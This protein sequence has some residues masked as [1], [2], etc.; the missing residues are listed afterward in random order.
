MIL[1][2]AFK[3]ALYT[4]DS[5]RQNDSNGGLRRFQVTL[6]PMQHTRAE[7]YC[8]ERTCPVWGCG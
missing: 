7:R 8:R 3:L 5:F 1:V 4:S 6:C 2:C